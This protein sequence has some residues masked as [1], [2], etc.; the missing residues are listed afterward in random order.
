[1]R[2]KK[3]NFRLLDWQLKQKDIGIKWWEKILLWFRKPYYGY[4]YGFG[5]KSVVVVAKKMFGK[6]YIVGEYE[7]EQTIA[8][9][10][11]EAESIKIQSEAIMSQGGENY[12]N[13]KAVEKWN[14][15]LPAQMIP[16]ATLPFINL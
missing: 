8:K 1:M 4:D 14:G 12:V 10:K 5:D 11:A 13:M 9:A 15:V 2:D 16:N 7:A 6:I 3:D